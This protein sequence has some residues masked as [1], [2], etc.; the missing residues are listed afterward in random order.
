MN[1]SF[2]VLGTI[3]CLT[4]STRGEDSEGGSHDELGHLSR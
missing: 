4:Y 1:E 2:I 3:K